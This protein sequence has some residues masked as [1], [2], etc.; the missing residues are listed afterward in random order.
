MKKNIFTR[1]KHNPMALALRNH[2]SA[3]VRS[4]KHYT[5]KVKHKGQE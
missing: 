2:K 4:R 1:A 5:R 3:K